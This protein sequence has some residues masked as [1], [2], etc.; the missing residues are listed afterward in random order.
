MLYSDT[1]KKYNTEIQDLVL[2]DDAFH[3]LTMSGHQRGSSCEWTKISIRPVKNKGIRQ[4]QFTYRDGTQS[5]IK[6]YGV[7]EVPP[8]LSE[9]LHLPFKQFHVQCSHGDLQVQITKK[10][11]VLINRNKPSL[12]TLPSELPH[13]RMKSYLLP[14]D[15]ADE[16]LI[17]IGIMDQQGR[18]KPTM[19]AKFRQINEFLRHIEPYI[20]DQERGGKPIRLVDC[21]C[22]SAYLT[23]AAYHYLKVYKGFEV[24]V[25]GI[26]H[27]EK[28]IQKCRT[29]RDRLSWPNLDFQTTPI[30]AY[31]PDTLPDMVFSLHACDIATDEALAKS[32]HWDAKA[33]IAAPCCQSELRKQVQSEILRPMM[34]DGLLKHRT[35]DII[36][37]A[38]RALLL[39]MMG[40]KTDI[41]EFVYPAHTP[42]NLMIRGLSGLNLREPSVIEEY[43]QLKAFWHI[44]PALERLIGDP[45]KDLL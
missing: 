5:I 41:V 40:Y 29:L 11:K 33:I 32:I 35:A 24:H 1:Q 10:G 7:E 22:G 3:R 27:N 2:Q 8:H 38:V 44:D 26:D 6:N 16:F 30:K 31:K 12:K 42:K 21:G 15:T 19:Q 23:F 9:A 45:V 13:N 25:T 20:V 34:R 36:T 28:I 14:I 43:K 17:A 37:D 4:Y 39:R 18:I